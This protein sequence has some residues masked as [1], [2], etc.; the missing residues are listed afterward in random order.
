MGEE[1]NGGGTARARGSA[2]LVLAGELGLLV[3][4]APCTL[5]FT[6]RARRFWCSAT[7]LAREPGA[8]PG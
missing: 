7:E 8:S 3:D 5:L 6:V 1:E 4:F 2:W